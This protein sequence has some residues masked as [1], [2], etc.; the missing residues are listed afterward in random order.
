MTKSNFCCAVSLQTNKKKKHSIKRKASATQTNYVA[1]KNLTEYGTTYFPLN[2]PL[3]V[4]M[5][6]PLFQKPGS[7]NP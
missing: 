6:A 1:I 4:A 3:S 5:V 7:P 2:S